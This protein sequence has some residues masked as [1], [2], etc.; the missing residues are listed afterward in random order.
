MKYWLTVT[1]CISFL[2][3]VML[4]PTEATTL[5]PVITE[6]DGTCPSQEERDN[7]IQNITA[8]VQAI[9]HEYYSASAV[10]PINIACG[11]GQWHQV[12]YLNMS[13]PS[14]QCPSSWREYNESGVRT[15]RRPE[16]SGGS[17]PG[18]FY[19]TGQQYSKVCGRVIG[20]Q[21]GT[22]NAYGFS[23]TR[24]TIIDSYYVY[25]VSITHGSP[26][27][28]IWTFASGY[29]DGSGGVTADQSWNCPCS[30]PCSL[31]N[32]YPPSFVGDNYYCESGNS[33]S[34]SITAHL[35]S[36]DPLWDGQQ[37]EGECCSNGKSPP[38]FSVELPNPTTDDIEVRICI[39]EPSLDDV[40]LEMLEI[41]IQ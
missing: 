10:N 18:T 9:L 3:M 13:D 32:I 22:T 16:S 7:A 20:Y 8:T 11:E 26:Q 39:P 15:C 24:H 25:G 19:M 1:L 33:G 37:C 29:S 5:N 17:C 2:H 30:D 6:V 40:A 27:N 35:Y 34:S 28:H 36:S 14:Q 31:D 4:Q 38:W 21:I 41:Y 23:A 12:A